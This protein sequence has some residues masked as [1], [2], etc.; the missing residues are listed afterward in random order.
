MKHKKLFAALTA[1]FTVLLAFVIFIMIWFWGDKYNGG[2]NFEG[3]G[4]FRS[5]FAI[6]G[7]SD[8]AVPQGI[9]TYRTTYTVKTTDENGEEK[10][11]QKSQDYFF[12]SA[13][14]DNR[15]SRIYVLGRDTGEVGYV[16]LKN[17]D[18]SDFKGHCGG[19]ATNGHTL[20]I[21]SDSRIYVARTDNPTTS[22]NIARDIIKAAEENGEVKFTASFH[23][24]CNA[25][26]LYYYDEDSGK[27]SYPSSSDRLYVGDF[28]GGD[29][30]TKKSHKVET[31]N[32]DKNTAFAYEYYVSTSD[33]NFGLSTISGNNAGY[34]E[35]NRA[36]PQIQKIFSITS[37]IQG[38]ARI[39]DNGIVLSQSSGLTN[40]RMYYYKF[41]W[42]SPSSSENSS[43]SYTKFAETDFVYDG[44]KFHS[45]APYKDTTVRIYFLDE[46]SKINDYSIP[47]MSEGIC[48]LDAKVYVLFQSGANK[49]KYL[50]R[51]PLKNVYSFT[52]RNNNKLTR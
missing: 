39:G 7:L 4:D 9:T 26:F 35:K 27:S 1:V 21:A 23:A 18:G 50:V 34:D 22:D 20:W 42:S 38:F 46:A 5:E 28:H 36:V 25:S 14:M 24:N 51:Q 19:I 11:E 41:N 48:T 49:Y 43:E 8:G 17:E 47:S 3:F 40:S 31:P 6:P 32:G 52:P 12:I 45:G 15:P 29:S 37:G 2:S 30:D 16:T 33:K 44:A 10:E 13:Y